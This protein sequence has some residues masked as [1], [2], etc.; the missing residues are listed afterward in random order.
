VQISSLPACRGDSAQIDQVFSNLLSNALK[1]LDPS[2]PG[3][4]SISGTVSKNRAIYRVSD[5]GIGIDPENQSNIFEA[6]QRF[7][8]SA[9]PGEGLGLSIARRIV[10]KH[11]GDISV[12]SEPG[13]GS[14]FSV[15][16]PAP[17]IENET[18]D[19]P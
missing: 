2:R 10:Q 19:K 9:A 3:Q 15:T 12:E 17:Q 8:S 6:F 11:G 18:P 16:L 13:K 1:Y 5:N 14:C 4:I 7:H